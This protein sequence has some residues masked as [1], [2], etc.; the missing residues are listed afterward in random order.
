MR[1]TPGS[2]YR[3]RTVYTHNYIYLCI[4]IVLNILQ[5]RIASFLNVSL[6][7]PRKFLSHM[8]SL[9]KWFK[10]GHVGGGGFCSV[11]ARRNSCLLSLTESLTGQAQRLL[12][13]LIFGCCLGCGTQVVGRLL[14]RYPLSCCVLGPKHFLK[15][16][17]L[18][19]LHLRRV[20]N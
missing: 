4:C 1:I 5:T 20:A 14:Q 15:E 6:Q 12:W 7:I 8:N 9:L 10:D 13:I 19:V 18:L 2:S 16:N 11:N 3:D 17:L